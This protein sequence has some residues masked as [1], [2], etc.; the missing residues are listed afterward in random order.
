MIKKI[1]LG[2]LL[3][4]ATT[5]THAKNLPNP[6]KNAWALKEENLFLL[7][8]KN[9]YAHDISWCIADL[10]FDGEQIKIC[11]F[12]EG[13][14]SQFKGYDAL[15][16]EGK[17]WEEFWQ[18]LNTFNLPM[19]FVHK[20]TRSNERKEFAYDTF[21]QLKGNAATSHLAVRYPNSTAKQVHKKF[22]NHAG[23]ILLESLSWP[24]AQFKNFCTQH[25]EFI[26]LGQAVNYTVRTKY[27]TNKLFQ[28]AGITAYKPLFK[29]YPKKYTRTLAQTIINDLA[30]N[31]MFV[32]KP[33]SAS[34]GHG[35]IIIDAQ[36]LDHTL[37]LIFEQHAKIKRDFSDN[38]Y[39]Y[40]THDFNK[41]FLVEAYA[42]SKPINANNKFY[43]AT[44]R[45]IFSLFNNDGQM[46]IYFFD[47]YWKLPSK[48]LNEYG[49][50]NDKH[51]S[52]IVSNG[53]SSA[54]VDP[55]DFAKVKQELSCFLPV[56]YGKM[57]EKI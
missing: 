38:S 11:E 28:D 5:M 57:L 8:E 14:Y 33:I 27:A 41:Q 36:H 1:I 16:G 10:K 29:L 35:I 25:P 39:T 46:G 12:G 19:W 51:K 4:M 49:T 53:M 47:A 23:I 22:Q 56:L 50:L 6:K 20:R 31:T 3:V 17:L 2:S 43:D 13:R 55:A 42:P 24:E 44:M 26:T 54:P 48:A 18:F 37:N 30:P 9:S 34:C 21:T 45:V 7:P 15:Y 32:I 40:W 52:H